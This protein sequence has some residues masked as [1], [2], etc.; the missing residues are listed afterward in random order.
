MKLAL[1]GTGL[2]GYP[3]A[4]RLLK[5]GHDVTVYNRTISKMEGL[6]EFGAKI[7]EDPKTA[8]EQTQCVILV[9]SDVRAIEE[10]IFNG[11]EIDLSEKTFIQM[12]T[13]SS[14]ESISIQ[15]KIYA[16]G[17]QYFECPVLGSRKE[18]ADGTLILMV[19]S[20]QEKY[21]HWKQFLTCFGPEP[22]YVG[23]VGKAAALKLA[24][25]QL[26]AMHITG[27]SL[28]MGIIQKNGVDVDKFMEILRNSSL[29]TPMFD[30]KL[31]NL[32]SR[33]FSKPNFPVKHL[34]KDTNL[35]TEEIKQKG[36]SPEV[37]EAIRHVF[38]KAVENGL[39]ELDYSAVYNVICPK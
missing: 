34:L 1:I 3:M 31:E 37:I 2:L 12:G 25:N 7:V 17:G 21:N 23:E 27:F 36:L 9:L 22:I 6:K 15:K 38:E 20:T 18:A 14:N 28:S 39:G 5:K 16:Y 11:R 33:K 8:I 30:K 29:Y 32:Q 24:L 35:I 13:I 26:I 19:G 10:T 4:E